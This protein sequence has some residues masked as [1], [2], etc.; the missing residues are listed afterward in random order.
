MRIA[1]DLIELLLCPS[2]ANGQN[3]SLIFSNV[4][5]WTN[6]TRFGVQPLLPQVKHPSLTLNGFD[7]NAKG[8][9]RSDS[10]GAASTV[11]LPELAARAFPKTCTCALC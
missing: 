6:N 9:K 11:T 4:P 5:S 1:I 2:F 8:C 3:A 7:G 10:R